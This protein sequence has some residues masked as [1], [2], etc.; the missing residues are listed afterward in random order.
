[1]TLF[2]EYLE[3]KEDGAQNEIELIESTTEN[4]NQADTF[5]LI[6]LFKANQNA[7]R[8]DGHRSKFWNCMQKELANCDIIV[9]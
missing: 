9:S 8:A 3:I 4:W 1:M 5:H 7:Y 6:E 2:T